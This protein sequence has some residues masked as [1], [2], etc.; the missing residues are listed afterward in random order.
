[1]RCAHCGEPA[2]TFSRSHPECRERYERA[3]KAL[4]GYFAR[5]LTDD[6]TAERFREISTEVARSARIKDEEFGRIVVSGIGAM[7]HNALG[8]H[9]LTEEESRRIGALTKAFG[10]GLSDLGPLGVEFAKVRIL[11]DLDAGRLPAIAIDLAGPLAPNLARGEKAIFAFT[12]VTYLAMRSQRTYEGGS[13]GVSI[14][15]M[16]GVYYRAGAQR[17]QFVRT[18]SLEEIAKG[19]LVVGSRYVYFV[20]A[21]K[22]LRIDVRKIISAQLYD[23]G[24]SI[25]QGGVRA[26]PI[27]FKVDD[28]PFLANVLA[29]VHEV[30]A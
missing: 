2:G 5:F 20:S 11:T 29:R 16:P 25:L 27:V 19:G 15:L 13:R 6:M 7:I 3:T 12:G 18:E 4:P 14:R 30:K 9:L 21:Q 24:V 23:D 17:G 28:P 22:A 10:Y 8:D 26:K 1:M